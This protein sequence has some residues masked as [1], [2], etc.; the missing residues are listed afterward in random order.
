MGEIYRHCK[1]VLIY[2]APEIYPPGR[3]SL[4][5]DRF[6]YRYIESDDDIPLQRIMM[7]LVLL[8]DP[9]STW[10]PSVSFYSVMI[11]T[12]YLDCQHPWFYRA[13]DIQEAVLA[14]KATI[15]SGGLAIGLEGLLS[16]IDIT[17]CGDRGH[18]Y[19]R[20]E[21]LLPKSFTRSPSTPTNVEAED[22]QRSS[23]HSGH[24]VSRK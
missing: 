4:T 14:P 17:I 20:G 13:W 9:K 18:A 10:R 8:F 1:E 22:L 3:K 12:V 6:E 16:L 11:A 21:T 24:S 5:W 15:L 2:L 23:L 7:D 19:H